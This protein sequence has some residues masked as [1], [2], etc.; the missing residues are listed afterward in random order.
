M[1]RR[2]LIPI[3]ITAAILAL[4]PSARRPAEQAPPAATVAPG[5]GNVASVAEPRAPEVRLAAGK[6]TSVECD[7]WR[8]CAEAL[9]VAARKRR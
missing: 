1:I 2:N 8:E 6:A 9:R 3:A 4:G 7:G 5:A